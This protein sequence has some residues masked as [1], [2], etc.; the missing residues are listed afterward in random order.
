MYVVFNIQYT[1]TT[2]LI[3]WRVH[4][5]INKLLEIEKDLQYCKTQ[6]IEGFFYLSL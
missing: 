2:R 3:K 4:T 1:A 5:L 6:M